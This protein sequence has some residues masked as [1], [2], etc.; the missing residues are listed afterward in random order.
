MLFLAICK[1]SNPTNTTNVYYMTIQAR[2]DRRSPP[3]PWG[4]AGVG[5]SN[6]YLGS[7]FIYFL[8]VFHSDWLEGAEGP[9]QAGASLRGPRRDEVGEGPKAPS[10]R[11]YLNENGL[12]A[13]DIFVQKI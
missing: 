8:Y 10:L 13:G 11:V 9:R 1:S 4:G 7:L 5:L 3:F 12:H 2:Q 6:Q